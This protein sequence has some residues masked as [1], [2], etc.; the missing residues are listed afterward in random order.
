M[1]KRLIQFRV[2]LGQ[3]SHLET[4]AVSLHNLTHT[5]LRALHALIPTPHLTL[6]LNHL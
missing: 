3:E 4:R 1:D 2:S 6:S 5:I